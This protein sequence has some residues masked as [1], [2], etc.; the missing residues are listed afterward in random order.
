MPINKSA[1]AVI[2]R[3]Q[4]DKI[5]YLLIQY[6]AG[7]WG[8]PRGLMEKEESL[9]E[10]AHREI[11][12]ETGLKNLSFIPGFKEQAKFFYKFKGKKIMKIVTYFLAETNNKKIVLSH[13]HKDYIWL[14]YEQ[15]LKRLIFDNPRKVLE[16]ANDFL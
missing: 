7:Y 10:T 8:F 15:A 6:E 11:E 12:E 2:F 3:K 13:E 1:G 5:K 16:K 9:E 4:G 14:E